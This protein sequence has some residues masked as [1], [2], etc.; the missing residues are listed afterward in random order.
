MQQDPFIPPFHQAKSQ[1]VPTGEPFRLGFSYGLKLLIGGAIFTL[2]NVGILYATDYYFP[3]LFI[4]GIVLTLTAPSF[5][6]FAGGMV[7]EKPEPK[8]MM[9]VLWKNAPALHRIM[10]IV[11]GIGALAFAFW[12]VMSFLGWEI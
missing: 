10:W 3:K 1:Q 11:W 4:A 2:I 6:L 12:F 8:D 5:M 7:Y 9:K